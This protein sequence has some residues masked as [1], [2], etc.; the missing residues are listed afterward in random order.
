MHK[1]FAIYS[2]IIAVLF[3]VIASSKNTDTE[4]MA[5]MPL[6]SI[7]LTAKNIDLAQRT[8]WIMKVDE[9]QYTAS[10]SGNTLNA[11]P[12]SEPFLAK[13]RK[14]EGNTPFQY[15]VSLYH[16]SYF[17]NQSTIQRSLFATS[18][19]IPYP[20]PLNIEDQSTKEKLLNA[21]LLIAHALTP[22]TQTLSG[23]NFVHQSTLLDFETSG[24]P[25][26]S[27]I[28]IRH[29]VE[30]VPY[31]YKPNFYKVI[32]TRYWPE[33]I[34]RLGADSMKVPSPALNGMFSNSIYTFKVVYDPV[35]KKLSTQ[36]VTETKW[37]DVADW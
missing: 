11:S 35:T 18:P 5:A 34:V 30:T 20:L 29:A 1:P 36:N 12:L 16:K 23:I 25:P 19:N 10:L 24:L 3:Y 13:Y 15:T 14:E 26:G 33:I 31:N 7:T 27:T 32:T 4:N 28:S 6:K 22:P 2:L 17:K 21:D 8:D 9:S 37:S